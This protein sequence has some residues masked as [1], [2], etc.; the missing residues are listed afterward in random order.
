[1][2]KVIWTDSAIQVLNEIGEY[3][4]K[5]SPRYAEL[6]VSRLFETT[7]IVEDH[8]KAGRIVPEYRV[9]NIRELIYGS[10]RIIYKIINNERID[11]LTV[12]NSMSF[13]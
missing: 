3:I 6:T 9:P 12:H 7:T 11:I 2:V 10:Y 8:P 5:E 4:S 13:S 1:M